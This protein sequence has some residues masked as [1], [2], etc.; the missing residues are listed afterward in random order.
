VAEPTGEAKVTASHRSGALAVTSL[1]KV[2]ASPPL[3]LSVTGVLADAQPAMVSAATASAVQ[4]DARICPE[5]DVRT[6]DLRAMDGMANGRPDDWFDRI[7]W[8]GP[9]N[10]P[11]H[12][13]L[14]R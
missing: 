3:V 11:L 1:W 9:Q 7:G 4:R 10:H 6:R 12:H 8:C 13:P 2:Q 5:S 14:W